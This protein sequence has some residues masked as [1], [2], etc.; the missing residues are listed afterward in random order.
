MQL[1][2]IAKRVLGME[3]GSGTN[4]LAGGV[5]SDMFVF[6]PADGGSH[7]V[8]DLEPW[9]ILNLEAFGYADADAARAQMSEVGADL[10]FAD[11]ATTITLR[12]TGLEDIS[13]QMLM[14]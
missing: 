2:I 1:N 12:N 9:D 6:S 5:M 3:G 4:V 8:L 10:V 7:D 14:I 11:Q 13:D